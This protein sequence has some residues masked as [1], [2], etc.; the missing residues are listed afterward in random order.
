MILSGVF[1]GL[2]LW[3]ES[4]LI[5]CYEYVADTLLEVF[6]L[7][8]DYFR[9][10]LPLTDTLMEV[11]WAA[12]WA[13]LLGNLVFQA[14]KGMLSGIGFEA[15]EPRVLFCRTAVFAFLLAVCPQ[16]CAAC[17]GLTGQVV[18]LL[19]I[20][21][22]VEIRFLQEGDF[23]FPAAWL[24]ALIVD[25]ILI[26]QVLR[27]FLSIAERYVLLILLTVCAPLAFGLG[28]SKQTEDIFK[29]WA[30][31]LGGVCGM[32]ILNVVVLKLMLAGMAS[33]PGDIMVIPWLLLLMGLGKVGKKSDELI[34]RIG[35]N[36]VRTGESIG[37]GLPGML[38]MAAVRVLA[39]DVMGGHGKPEGRKEASSRPAERL[40]S[41]GEDGGRPAPAR[42][43][44]GNRGR[45][46]GKE[47]PIPTPASVQ[48]S[49]GEQS[50]VGGGTSFQ[51]APPPG[52]SRP[53]RPDGQPRSAE[54]RETRSRPAPRQRLDE[55]G[56][57]PAPVRSE[58]EQ[59][60][61]TSSTAPV[62]SDALGIQ[63]E[64][65]GKSPENRPAPVREHP[66][67]SGAARNKE[68]PDRTRPARPER[69]LPA[70]EGQ[71]ARSKPSAIRREQA[72]PAPGE[73]IREEQPAV[74]RL[75]SPSQAERPVAERRTRSVQ[76]RQEERAHP[77]DPASR[78]ER[79][80]APALQTELEQPFR[81][82]S[83]TQQADRGISRPVREDRPAVPVVSGGFR[84][85][86]RPPSPVVSPVGKRVEI[87][88]A[89]VRERP[90]GQKS[91]EHK[92]QRG[93]RP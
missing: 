23:H 12:G 82:P 85:A 50:P 19:Q 61:R 84:G 51:E 80:T 65:R 89:Q 15:E 91:A 72:C 6:R 25:V 46:Y 57:M 9:T 64:R 7:D 68:Q 18:E 73:R 47:I 49:L 33:P 60:R 87:R 54:A 74:G 70:A 66:T 35:L 83:S 13:L 1:Q 53:R 77:A 52:K 81:Q 39:R 42:P 27:I 16:I 45:N 56:V 24:L 41:R 32:T 31:L 88:S 62:T 40:R 22:A 30:R 75:L 36:S 78:A 67:V 90:K 58:A 71:R 55:S 4:L 17:M 38:A 10:A 63:P 76:V 86:E 28:G 2:I 44:V 59:P 3:F 26:Y 8:L 21:D 11:L 20:P 14:M 48:A 5:S 93:N 37:R 92:N 69:P 34:S 29:G 79:T 43:P